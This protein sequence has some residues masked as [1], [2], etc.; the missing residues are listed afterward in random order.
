MDKKI[1]DNKGLNHSNLKISSLPIKNFKIRDSLK[2]IGDY[3]A[4]LSFAIPDKKV[5]SA[6][7]NTLSSQK[8]MI[9]SIPDIGEK[10]SVEGTHV[11]SILNDTVAPISNAVADIGLANANATKLFGIGSINGKQLKLTQDISGLA[12]DTIKEYQEN[13][14]ENLRIIK[15]SGLSSIENKIAPSLKI[16]SS[17]ISEMMRSLPT[18]PAQTE[19]KLPELGSS[20]EV[21]KINQDEVS[22]HQNDLDNLLKEIDPNLIEIRKAVWDTFNAKGKDYI[23]QSS[24]SMRRLIDKLLR[25]LAPLEKVIKTDFFEKKE[26]VKD[27]NGRPTRKARILYIVGWDKN[28][29]KHLTRVVKGF[30]EEYQNLSA[31]DHSPIDKHAFVHGTFI[32]IEGFL[33]SILTSK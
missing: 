9:K 22:K 20:R 31:W 14:G 21:I 3:S 23:G 16:A 11:A 33:I 10:I 4:G 25:K 1:N 15:D 32:T 28:K 24:S 18:F 12:L 26:G 30:M 29:A 27:T 7:N 2:V 6:Y 5:M 17:G 13:V 8:L 19:L